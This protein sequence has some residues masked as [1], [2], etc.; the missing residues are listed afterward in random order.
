MNLFGNLLWLI[1]GGLVSALS[2]F[3]AGLLCCLTIVGIPVGLQCFKIAALSLSPFGKEVVYEGG[4]VSLLANIL[5]LIVGI[6][7]ALEHF[8]MGIVMCCTIIGI[9]FGLQYF[10]L[11]KLSFLPFGAVIYQNGF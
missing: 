10:K 5:W 3:L 6:P 11:A 1:F 8:A 2:W 7:L 4:A 9:P